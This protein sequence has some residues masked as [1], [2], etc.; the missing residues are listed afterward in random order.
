MTPMGEAT[1]STT[2][3]G[4]LDSS[5][6][7]GFQIRIFSIC[8]CL[9]FC[10]GFDLSL[11]GIS[12]PKI[13]ETL[14]VKPAALGG[15][16]SA[17]NVGALVGAL[18]LG[19]L[20]DRFGRKR[21]LVLSAFLFGIFTLAIASIQSMEMLALFRFCAGLG[22]GGAIPNALAF[23]SE[24]APGRKRATL[25]T[26]MYAGVAMGAVVAGLLA[27]YLLPHFGWRSL[28]FVGGLASILIG[29]IAAVSMPESLAFLV[30]RGRDRDQ[31]KIRG[32]LS[33]L[34]P[35][36]P[37]DG[38]VRFAPEYKQPG[39]PIAQLF[40]L[41]RARNTILLW[42]A[43]ILSYYLLWLILSWTPMLLKKSGASPQ[44]FSLA[45]AS[46][47]FGSVIAT[48][49]IGMLMDKFNPLHILKVGFGLACLSIMVFGQFAAS[50]FVIVA[51]VS[52]VMG[53]FVIGSNAGL[54]ALASL[55][56]P[57]DIRGTGLGWAT[58]IGRTG[59]L[60]APVAGGIM[61]A[62]NWSVNK[63]CFTNALLALVV[64]GILFAM[65]L[66]ATNGKRS[67]MAKA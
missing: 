39:V 17:G 44:E 19:L 56:Y 42:S 25:A 7:S 40:S 34:N 31:A 54:M 28:F 52:F 62:G 20:A 51:M 12:L 14:Q 35:N 5:P 4:L 2:V 55:T 48:L 36:Q 38:G 47:N 26:A 65:G 27:S 67:P 8:F 64:V 9:T 1:A 58:G 6:I 53:F 18:V 24:Y 33:K 66:G 13:A 43:F 60:I 3:S 37:V 41:G 59:S 57:T 63:I 22:L 10:D 61:L 15:V 23:G 32:I 29:L 49:T 45:F 16:L 30:Q 50:P 11:V 46:I 21:M